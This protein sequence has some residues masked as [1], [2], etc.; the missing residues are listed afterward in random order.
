PEHVLKN[1][2]ISSTKIRKALLSGD[3]NTAA[4]CLG[5]DYFF[6]G[7]VVEGKKLGRT[8]GFP[9]A[10]LQVTDQDKLI[11][12]HGVYAVQVVMEGDDKIYGGMMNIGTRP[13]INGKERV[14]EVNIFDLEKDLYGKTLKVI[15]KKW[16]RNEE[17]FNNLDE[18]KMQIGRDKAD[19]LIAL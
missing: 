16:L 19:A 18:L 1:I 14:I 7:L 13:T 4:A 17:K 15:F 11:P 6:S 8:I 2:S 10:N 9:T 12:A 5:Y 3:I